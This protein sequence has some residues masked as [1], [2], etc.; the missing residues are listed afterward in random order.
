MMFSLFGFVLVQGHEYL[1]EPLA[2]T[3]DCLLNAVV[4][5][6]TICQKGSDDV[7]CS[8]D[9]SFYSHLF[10]VNDAYSQNACGG[11]LQVKG[12]TGGT[13]GLLQHC[14][15][16]ATNPNLFDMSLTGPYPTSQWLAA[17]EVELRVRGFFHEGVMRISLCYREDSSCMSPKDFN[18]YVLGFHFTEGT[19]GTGSDIYDVEMSFKVKVP[20]RDGTAVLQLL[21][22]AEDVRSYVS[23]A[24]VEISGAKATTGSKDD[25]VCNGHPLCNCTV[26]SADEVALGQSC[27]RGTAASTS[28]GQATG[29]DI[30]RQYKEQV[31]VEEFCSLCI[32]N[33]CPSTCG[34]A[35]KGYY[36][37]DKCTNSPVIDNCNDHH[38]S[39]LPRYVNCSPDT[40]KSSDWIDSVFVV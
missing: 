12:N 37:G 17:S 27:P 39:G 9:P 4:M 24:D 2:R 8:E 5:G 26:G 7:Q 35:Y 13:Q 16:I 11:S 18:Q 34:G 1:K 40:C 23:C 21:V 22:D 19:A 32:T 30:V 14:G 28:G 25:Y 29:T 20:N 3:S 36:Q 38:Q 31:G 10:Q 15:D 6:S 33:G